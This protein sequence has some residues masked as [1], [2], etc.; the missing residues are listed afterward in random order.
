MGPNCT[1]DSQQAKGNTGNKELKHTV[2]SVRG[3]HPSK[4]YFWRNPFKATKR[5]FWASFQ[6]SSSQFLGWWSSDRFMNITEPQK[7]RFP[8]FHT[9]RHLKWA[10]DASRA[11]GCANLRWG[12]G[13]WVVVKAWDWAAERSHF[14]SCLCHWLPV[15]HWSRPAP[16]PLTLT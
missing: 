1:S 2:V 14:Y 9:L 4:I 3:V 10:A 11:R 5:S 6:T 12:G 16:S 13:G 8:Q 15:G 7:C